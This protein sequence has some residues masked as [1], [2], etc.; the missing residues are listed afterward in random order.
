MPKYTGKDK[1]DYADQLRSTKLNTGGQH[2]FRFVIWSDTSQIRHDENQNRSL[3][4]PPWLAGGTTH[5]LSQ[6][7]AARAGDVKLS[8]CGGDA[9]AAA[10]VQGVLG[11]R[12]C[13]REPS[14]Q[15]RRQRSSSFHRERTTP[16]GTRRDGRDGTGRLDRRDG[17]RRRLLGCYPATVRS[18]TD[19]L[20]E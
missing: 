8:G 13:Q 14:H 18:S 2:T 20:L 1:T 3:M 9:T 4:S 17:R 19:W 7:L 16:S 12:R 15:Q 10:R 5:R 6:L 11:D